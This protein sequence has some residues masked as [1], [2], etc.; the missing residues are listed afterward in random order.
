LD[1][2]YKE[3]ITNIAALGPTDVADNREIQNTPKWTLSGSVDY[4]TPAF[5]GRLNVNSTLSYRSA[6]QQF[7]LPVPYID[8]GGFALWDANMVW[9]ST[10]N[11]WEL[12]LHAKNIANKKYI[13][14]GYNFLLVNPITGTPTLTSAGL[15][16]AAL[17]RT[18][19]ATAF[20]GNPRQL[21]LSA[22]Y[23]F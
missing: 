8:Q 18:G 5:G 21:W 6:S 12:G 16:I 3:F 20:Y 13:V 22:A 9:R 23:N 1:G 19:T 7:E 10:G 17:G 15:P 11:H 2:K 4:D 14:G